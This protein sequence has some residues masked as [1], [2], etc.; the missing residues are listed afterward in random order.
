MCHGSGF[1]YQV[2]YTRYHPNTVYLKVVCTWCYGLGYTPRYYVP[3]RIRVAQPRPR[4]HKPIRPQRP[5][6]R[7]N[8]RDNHSFG[9]RR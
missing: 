3:N 2:D 4:V 9:K 8:H 6:P 1:T 5:Q 7:P